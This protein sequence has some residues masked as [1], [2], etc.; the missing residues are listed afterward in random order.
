[1][2]LKRED[3][4][5]NKAIAPDAPVY[6][7]LH[8]TL[9]PYITNSGEQ[10]MLSKDQLK[11]IDTPEELYGQQV[12]QDDTREPIYLFD[13][14]P[15]ESNFMP[16]PPPPGVNVPDDFDDIPTYGLTPFIEPMSPVNY[17][18]PDGEQKE[19][20]A[21]EYSADSD[22]KEG[23]TP[24]QVKTDTDERTKN[25]IRNIKN[26]MGIWT[27]G[28]REY[29][30]PPLSPAE[31]QPMYDEYMAKKKAAALKPGTGVSPAANMKS[32]DL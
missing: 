13:V 31:W 27:Q 16:P 21:Y 9:F 1:M 11:G 26:N 20:P 10:Y 6:G 14:D 12:T 30:P 29:P 19:L 4:I 8:G 2:S 17:D 5:K 28:G 23:K 15:N 7:G 25:Y 18:L 3:L 22:L 24:E 32:G